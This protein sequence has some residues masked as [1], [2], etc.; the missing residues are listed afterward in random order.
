MKFPNNEQEAAEGQVMK[1]YKESF[2]MLERL[3]E[4]SYINHLAWSLAL[5]FLGVIFWM[6]LALINAENQRNAL[7]THQC[8]D[9]VF[10]NELD[11]KCL[12]TVQSREHWWQHLGYAMT[13]LSPEK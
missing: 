6:S 9:R 3:F 12:L 7:M 1:I 8:M 10:K 4:W 13:H 5:I 2:P 11:K